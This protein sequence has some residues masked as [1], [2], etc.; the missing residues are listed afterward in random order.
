MGP[1]HPC[2]DRGPPAAEGAGSGCRTP[3]VMAEFITRIRLDDDPC[4]MHNFPFKMP[5][6]QPKDCFPPVCFPDLHLMKSLRRVKLG[7]PSLASDL[8]QEGSVIELLHE[9]RRRAQ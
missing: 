5:D 6:L 3:R 7:K 1:R 8:V 4:D 9:A 2:L